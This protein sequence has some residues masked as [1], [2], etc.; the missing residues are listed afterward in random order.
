[1]NK[2][3]ILQLLGLATRARMMISGEELVVNDV[4]KGKAKLVIIAEDASENTNKKLH[5]KCKSFNVDILV[6][7]T[8]YELGHAIG[9]EE[10]VV[11]AITDR[12]F[13]KKITSLFNEK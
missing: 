8:R 7:G 2:Q 9:K 12:G 10:R 3:K 13:A 4:R 5:D 11:I 6:L 1:M